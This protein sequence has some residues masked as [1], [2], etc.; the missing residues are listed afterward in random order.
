MS[1]KEEIQE[2]SVIPVNKDKTYGIAIDS[3]RFY[4]AIYKRKKYTEDQS[5]PYRSNGQVLYKFYKAGDYSDWQLAPRPYHNSL[6]A[7]LKMVAE[8][9]L[10][11]GLEESR[12]L[13]DLAATIE[14]VKEEVSWIDPTSPS[15][16]EISSALKPAT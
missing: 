2:S 1:S 6:S 7:A 11:D 9:M 13:L 8:L 4:V 15:L 12:D 5:I 14:K 3:K 10:Q 16:K